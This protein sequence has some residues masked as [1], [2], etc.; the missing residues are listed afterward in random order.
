MRGILWEDTAAEPPLSAPAFAGEAACSV[1]VIGGG[2]AGLSAALHLAGQGT[3]CCLLEAG[4]VGAGASG[5]NNGQVIPGLKLAPDALE[6]R[7]GDAGAAVVE[8]ASGAADRVFELIERHAIACEPDRRGWLRAAHSGVAL[9][10]VE[11]LARAWQA[12]G[13]PVDLLDAGATAQALGSDFYLGGLLDRRAG[14]LQPLAYCRG[15][16]RAARAAGAR[17]HEQSPVLSLRREGG[18]WLLETARGRL[19]A[20]AVILAVGA[21]GERLWPGWSRTYIAVQSMQ[22]ASA[23]LSDNLRAA[24][25]P[26]AS[27]MSDTR[28]LANAIRLDAAGR[29]CIAGRGPLSGRLDAGVV[30]QLQGGLTRLF[31]ALA[32]A[33]WSHAWP[34]RVAITRDELPRLAAPAPGLYG[35]VGF[36]GR[37]VAMATA[38][39]RAA[40]APALGR[41]AGFPVVPSAPVP[42]H[43][44]R[45]PLLAAAVSYYR[46][47]D[48]LGLASR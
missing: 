43:R 16:A 47:R 5:R 17:L 10:S 26:G 45:R 2:Y 40:A 15:L 34:G 48:G 46:L 19:T 33:A 22:L 3:D 27:A 32:E 42:L 39:G 13:A 12:R 25:M 24:V 41:P 35:I 31:P 37:G 44:L 8:T 7:Y 23:P 9:A 6:E 28:K 11:K 29:V 4:S 21:Y 1:A 36:N 20:E 30:R 14:R 38:L 18:C